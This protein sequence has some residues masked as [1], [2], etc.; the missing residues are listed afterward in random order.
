MLKRKFAVIGHPI[1]HTMS[2]FIHRRLFDLTGDDS[3]YTVLDI[4]SETLPQK[5]KELNE[6]AGYN[7]TIPNKRA[8][9]P[10]LDKLDKRAQLYALSIL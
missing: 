3:E 6:L 10:Y 1:S 2:P 9:I 7:I 4:P 8:I 5:I